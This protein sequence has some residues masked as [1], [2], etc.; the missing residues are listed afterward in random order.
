M[1]STDESRPEGEV[2][3]EREWPQ[4][5][6]AK[7]LAQG[8]MRA[9]GVDPE[10]QA[11]ACRQI[12]EELEEWR[13]EAVDVAL[14]KAM[15][16]AT[17]GPYL[18]VGAGSASLPK[19]CAWCPDPRNPDP[20]NH[21]NGQQHVGKVEPSK[22]RYGKQWA[23]CSGC[24]KPLPDD[25]LVAINELADAGEDVI[26]ALC[27]P[28]A[29]ARPTYFLPGEWAESKKAL[30]DPLLIAEMIGALP[31]IVHTR[32]GKNLTATALLLGT[33][34]DDIRSFYTPAMLL[35]LAERDSRLSF[36]EGELRFT[37]PI[38]YSTSDIEQRDRRDD[39][40]LI[41]VRKSEG[42]PW[43]FDIGGQTVPFDG[44]NKKQRTE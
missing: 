29:D 41:S 38:P 10:A 37:G 6:D 8:V 25:M 12:E 28:C 19:L 32:S 44:G 7:T 14:H 34:E 35:Q 4:V 15:E 17:G 24:D 2:R 22:V 23:S 1:N 42:Q 33:R 27:Q 43:H 36:E 26:E 39:P 31:V 13:K 30:D 40:V 16:V 5:R 3:P 18:T 11:K 20:A 21:P 9:C